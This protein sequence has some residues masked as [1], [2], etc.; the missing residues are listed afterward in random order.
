VILDSSAIVAVVF[1]EPG[2]ER[3]LDAIAAAPAVGVGAPTVVETGLVLAARLG[4]RGRSL[5]GQLLAAWQAEVIPFGE[6]HWQEA[7][8]AYERFGRARHP[9]GLNFGDCLTYAVAKLADQPVL[10]TGR[11]FTRTDIALA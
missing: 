8:A 4:E 5:L 10:A 2:Y 3:L 11:D 1:K 7:V 9:A 6:A